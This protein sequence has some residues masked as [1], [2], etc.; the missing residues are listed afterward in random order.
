MLRILL[1]T[2]FLATAANAGSPT[3]KSI[4]GST[5]ITVVTLS[6]WSARIENAAGREA[7]EV[8]VS[9]TNKTTKAVR[10]IDGYSAFVD[11]LGRDVASTPVPK[12]LHISPG[13]T[14]DVEP[15]RLPRGGVFDRLAT[16]NRADVVAAFCTRGVVFEDG[17]VMRY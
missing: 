12:D 3:A 15:F 14:V 17:E 8:R 7:L 11:V 10:M 4:C 9:I 2:A 5:N 1:A 6:D 13:Q 16:M